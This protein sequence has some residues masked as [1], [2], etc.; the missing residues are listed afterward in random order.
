[1]N[2]PKL[3]QGAAVGIVGLAIVQ[4]MSMYREA[5]PSLAEIRNSQPGAQDMR[6]RLLDADIYGG[7]A[8]LIIGGAVSVLTRDPLPIVL[9]SSGLV[10]L[11]AY[12]RSVCNSAPPGDPDNV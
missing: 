12:H 4:A 10:L 9:S 3:E 11:S 7:I 8:V 6:Q 2:V 1:M 5:A